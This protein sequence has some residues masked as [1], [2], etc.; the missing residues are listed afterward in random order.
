MPK[1]SVTKED[2]ALAITC[3][4]PWRLL[5]VTP[6]P[7]YKLKVEFIDGVHGLVDLSQRVVSPTAG[8]FAS[9][10]DPSLF[11]KVC[12]I[13]GVATWPNEIDLAPD[14]MYDEIKAH[15]EWV[16]K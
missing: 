16:L 8:V 9:L 14:V 11:N 12:I 2:T 1:K 4:A 5:K 10:K 3:N 13:Y 6:L 7:N 15:G